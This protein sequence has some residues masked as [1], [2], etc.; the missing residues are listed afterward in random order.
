M[1]I[2]SKFFGAAL[3][4]AVA[5]FLQACG[6][7][8]G[9]GGDAPQAT[10]SISGIASYDSVTNNT[11]NGGLNYAA[12]SNKPM[13]G[14]TL[15]AVSGTKVLASAT[16]SITGAYTLAVPANTSVSIQALAQ[17]SK[18]TGPATWNVNVIDN[19][20]DNL[21]GIGFVSATSGSSNSTRNI[22]APLG[23]NA[24]ANSY[25]QQRLSG[26]F[27]I[28]DTIYTSMQ[29]VTSVAPATQ[30]P[31][32]SVFW[33]PLNNP[34]ANINLAVGDI[35]TSFFTQIENTATNVVTARA[36]FILGKDG[37][38]TDEFD[39]GVIAHE[40]GHYLQSA[41]SRNHSTGG[42][43]GSVNG[44]SDKLD[45]TL[46][47]GEG[48]GYAFASMARNNPQNPD[49]V[50]PKQASG[51][52]IQTGTPPTAI[53][54]GWYTED[55]VQYVIYK[56]FTTQ[57]FA[58]IWAAV[59]GPMT[60]QNGLNSIFSFAAAVRSAGNIAV[61]SELNKLLNGQN[62]FIGATADEYG[63]N[64]TNNGGNALNLP[65]HTTLTATPAPVCFTDNTSDSA[66]NKL[67]E[68]RYLRFNLPTAGIKTVT[69]AFNAADNHDI[70]LDF[71]QLGAEK[72]PRY[73]KLTNSETYEGNFSAG[74]VVLR[75]RDENISTATAA[76]CITIK[77]N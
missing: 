64:E 76:N 49:S 63:T 68:R 57:G 32:L 72:N 19:T 66:N 7:G 31:E 69:V 45:M 38:D 8:G 71:Y 5:V 48:W 11:T 43:H 23:W 55:S 44:V 22:N 16:T 21:W 4:A 30:F 15:Q 18:T 1:R 73:T 46:A 62:I 35:G 6:G 14:I 65:V 67:G 40:F 12:I 37:V 33:S 29:L 47:Y 60:S 25:N 56:L 77:V 17:L 27:A 36:L 13:R 2:F 74:E 70:Y 34:S 10:V 75:A 3:V 20:D 26:P 54:S 51:S 50:G 52:V 39:G 53:N 9:G 24:A 58:P 59:S 28:L 61:T 42:L 41:F